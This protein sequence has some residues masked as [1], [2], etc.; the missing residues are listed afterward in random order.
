MV[1]DW[2]LR[3][4]SGI[5]TPDT[6]PKGTAPLS[7]IFLKAFPAKPLPSEPESNLDWRA[8]LLS[9]TLN[10]V[11]LPMERWNE[12]THAPSENNHVVDKGSAEGR[13]TPESLRSYPLLITSG[14]LYQPAKGAHTLIA[15][16]Y[17]RDYLDP[18][19]IYA[20]PVTEEQKLLEIERRLE[21]VQAWIVSH[22]KGRFTTMYRTQEVCARELGGYKGANYLR[23]CESVI[24]H[25]YFS[26]TQAQAKINETI[27]GAGFN[28]QRIFLKPRTV[29]NV[30]TDLQTG[31]LPFSRAFAED[32]KCIFNGDPC[33]IGRFVAR[34][35]IAQVDPEHMDAYGQL[36]ATSPDLCCVVSCDDTSVSTGRYQSY[37]GYVTDDSDFSQ[38]DQSQLK[39]LF[40]IDFKA[41]ANDVSPTLI[42]AFAT[43][44]HAI[45]SMAVKGKIKDPETGD[46]VKMR[47][48]LRYSMRTGVGTTS[49]F[50]GL[51]NIYTRI[52][53]LLR[54]EESPMSF[55]R[56]CAEL[57]IVVKL[58]KRNALEGAIFLRGWFIGPSYQWSILPSAVL[59]LGKLMKNPIALLQLKS[60]ISDA[61][62][63]KLAAQTMFY[64][65]M[66][67]VDVPDDYPLIGAFKRL[68]NRLPRATSERANALIMDEYIREGARYKLLR[69][70][71]IARKYVINAIIERYDISEQQVIECESYILSIP[72]LPALIQHPVFV[73]LRDVDYA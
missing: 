4:S 71:P 14:A 1:S 42:K 33:R 67:S 45:N 70:A 25:G 34:F 6:E 3:W 53:W 50:G 40:D 31:V 65:I 7:G 60:A 15:S 63:E 54:S 16:L 17:H 48:I 29:K 35:A 23:C 62:A 68:A 46:W 72:S 2:A 41:M 44:H 22:T 73:K 61:E 19:G 57:G 36:F 47:A 39:A 18:F 24:D 56:T 49:S 28:A 69:A 13:R 66:R 10:G 32:C 58:A 51:H 21:P 59:K 43:L 8:H 52:Y 9:V 20:D 11:P 27:K 37:F 5:Q 64:A 55:D 38:Y 30:S 26:Q 12:L